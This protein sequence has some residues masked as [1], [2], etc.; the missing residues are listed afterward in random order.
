[1]FYAER[2]I[3]AV[4]IAALGVGCFSGCF[5]PPMSTP[6]PDEQQRAV[7]PLPYDLAWDAVNQVIRET[8][9]RVQAQEPNY[10]IIEAVGPRF[11]LH[12]ADC[13][14]IKSIAG[15]Y[16]ADPELNGSSVYNFLVRPRGKEA[17]SVEVRATFN[18]PVKVPL[19]PAKDV[20]CVS[21]GIQESNLLRQ[22]LVAAKQTHR[23][24]FAKPSAPPPSQ[25]AP[26]ASS[27]PTPPVDLSAEGPDLSAKR[28]PPGTRST[29]EKSGERPDP[30]APVSGFS[31]GGG[32]PILTDPSTIKPPGSLKS[33]E[34]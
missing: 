9:M 18:S 29:I 5:Y 13:G 33:S 4:T 14:R 11:T 23:P 17:S 7:I 30:N 6:P 25:A 28:L 10:G 3:F 19:R 8:G 32:R 24:V 22:V 20:D 1:M 2:M 27:A 31:I 21:H 16:A 26:F 34:P 15:T 12:D